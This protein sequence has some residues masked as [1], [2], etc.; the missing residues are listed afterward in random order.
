MICAYEYDINKKT[1]TLEYVCDEMRER[2]NA[3]TTI[4]LRRP[5]IPLRTLD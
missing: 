3:I 5:C 1:Y 4:C 2:E